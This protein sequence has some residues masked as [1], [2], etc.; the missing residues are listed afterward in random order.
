M[1]LST[2]SSKLQKKALSPSSILKDIFVVIICICGIGG[3]LFFFY[4]AINRSLQNTGSENVATIT[5]KYRTAQRRFENRLVWEWL[6]N[7]AEIYNGDHIR[8]GGLSEAVLHFEDETVITLD[9]KTLIQVKVDEEKSLLPVFMRREKK[10]AEKKAG[11]NVQP[12][13]T[14]QP[15]S[16]KTVARSQAKADSKP[17]VTVTSG[18]I[19]LDTLAS[20]SE[21]S[22]S[23]IA[24]NHKINA[25]QNT[26]ALLT[27]KDDVVEVQTVTGEVAIEKLPDEAQIQAEQAD[28]ENAESKSIIITEGNKASI[29]KSSSNVTVTTI[30]ITEPVNNSYYLLAEE[31]KAEIGFNYSA[32]VAETSES[33]EAMLE[34]SPKEDFSELYTYLNLNVSG[35]GIHK[36]QLPAGRW[37]WRLHQKN[38]D[39]ALTDSAS[40]VF[41]VYKV[42]R[43][44]IFLPEE[45]AVFTAEYAEASSEIKNQNLTAKVLLSW[46]NDRRA[47]KYLVNAE[48]RQSNQKISF[49]SE[50][51]TCM[52]EIP[53]FISAAGNQGE[54]QEWTWT[55]TPLFME[56]WKG[57]TIAS[58]P[59]AF[60]VMPPEKAVQESL[61]QTEEVEAE[62]VSEENDELTDELLDGSENN[63]EAE[64]IESEIV[65]QP[66]KKIAE[67]EAED[68]KTSESLKPAIPVKEPEKSQEQKKPEVSEKSQEPEKT[69]ANESEGE[70]K[71]EEEIFVSSS[72]ETTALAAPE[73][74]VTLADEDFEEALI[75]EGKTILTTEFSEKSRWRTRTDKSTGGTSTASCDQIIVD[76]DGKTYSGIKF[77]SQINASSV[78]KL[79]SMLFMNGIQLPDSLQGSKGVIL[80]VIG[81]GNDY[82]LRI[83]VGNIEYGCKL[84]TKNGE[85]LLFDIPYSLF[86]Q[87]T[88]TE[89][90]PF[91]SDE[92][93]GI[94]LSPS[95][96]FP[97]KY[98]ITIFD[99]NVK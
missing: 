16:E 40:G 21:S 66:V 84:K 58:A 6:Q 83:G 27:V 37:S 46:K 13:K 52:T 29:D 62:T 49:Y 28:K 60:Y 33:I 24:G 12:A 41:T 5:F 81:D 44:E 50:V 85:V 42:N 9:E 72:T 98:E 25:G 96:P 59:A 18:A 71:F 68:K 38:E 93:T 26:Q 2:N 22:V 31:N 39:G 30:K 77:E 17:Q 80:K 69:S 78:K 70:I 56:S 74:K 89:L 73:F 43:P 7:N 75:Q 97:G 8:T 36:V 53:Y 87:Q 23:V 10:P 99:M 15:K 47:I 76:Y 14:V 55:V 61:P 95:V 65:E 45:N 92:I 48:C 86:R 35:S 54:A 94:T 11:Q 90:V 82:T 1:K 63:G 32:D 51:S 57:Q 4:K 79:S 88:G 20:S 3:S 34:I 64:I 67:K 19:K 91:D